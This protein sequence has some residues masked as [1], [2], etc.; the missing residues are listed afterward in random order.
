MLRRRLSASARARILDRHAGRCA[1]CRAKLQGLVEFDHAHALGMGGKDDED[2]LRP[3]CPECHKAK[4]KADAKARAKVRRLRGESRARRK[5][6][7]AVRGFSK[8]WR[9]KLDG[10]VVP[11]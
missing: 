11:R 6:K 1:G 8:R 5:I 9:R 10:S 3:L 2:N 4:T 7:I